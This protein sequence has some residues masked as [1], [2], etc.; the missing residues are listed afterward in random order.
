MKACSNQE[1]VL[2]RSNEFYLYAHC[3][4]E[5]P[6]RRSGL[7]R[8]MQLPVL[9]ASFHHEFMANGTRCAR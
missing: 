6:W 2:R 5:V 1:C 7:F 3:V 4:L 8:Q 9:D